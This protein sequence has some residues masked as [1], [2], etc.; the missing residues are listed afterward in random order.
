MGFLYLRLGDSP[1][2]LPAHKTHVSSAISLLT[3]PRALPSKAIELWSQPQEKPALE[4][5]VPMGALK[6]ST[7]VCSPGTPD[8]REMC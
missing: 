2:L 7:A 8:S 5:E 6:G 1:L 4:R 3:G